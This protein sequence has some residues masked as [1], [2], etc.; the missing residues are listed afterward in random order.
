[1]LKSLYKITM[2][3]AIGMLLIVIA[4]R[5]YVAIDMYYENYVTYMKSEEHIR[6][7]YRKLVIASGQSYP[8]LYIMKANRNVNAYTSSEGIFILGGMIDLIQNDDELALVL[9]HELSHYQLKHVFQQNPSTNSY[10]DNLIWDLQKEENADK[11]GAFMMLQAGYDVCNARKIWLR[12]KNEEG[13]IIENLSHPTNIFR[14]VN[15]NMPW[16]MGERL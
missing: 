10:N 4:S 15:L 9:G 13:D 11:A 5:V 8:P 16:C 6:D 2:L 7:V 12:L 14:Y 1:M 3:S